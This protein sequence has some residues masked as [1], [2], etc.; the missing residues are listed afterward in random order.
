MPLHRYEKRHEK[1]LSLPRFARRLLLSLL[2]SAGILSIALIIGTLGYHHFV[3]IGW[4]DSV[5]NASMIL[6][7]MGPVSP[8]PNDGAKIF[9]SLYALFSGLV[10]VTVMGVTL[11]PLVHRLLHQ[12]HIDEIDLER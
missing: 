10:F 2:F 1:V 4:I 6:T 8:M 5:L 12:F 9:A 7:G 3:A 11:A